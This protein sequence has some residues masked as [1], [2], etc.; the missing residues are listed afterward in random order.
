MRVEELEKPT[1]S[2][3]K[4]VKYDEDLKVMFNKVNNDLLVQK[5]KYFKY[6]RL[7]PRED[8]W[9]KLI[10]PQ[11]ILK[12]EFGYDYYLYIHS[13]SQRQDIVNRIADEIGLFVEY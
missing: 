9:C 5:I 6:S 8:I 2:K 12:I 13:S 1:L 3:V 4:N 7:A 11:S 10:H